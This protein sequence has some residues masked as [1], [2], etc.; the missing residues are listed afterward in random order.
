[1]IGWNARPPAPHAI[2]RQCSA[3]LRASQH[4]HVP[5]KRLVSSIVHAHDQ[6]R[7]TTRPLINATNHPGVAPKAPPTD[8]KEL[9]EHGWGEQIRSL[10][11]HTEDALFFHWNRNCRIHYLKNGTSGAEFHLSTCT[12]AAY[13]ALWSMRH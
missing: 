7:V 3:Q 12:S 10:Q 8:P 13:R 4:I 11:L 1:M 6:H 5:Q 9:D 2:V